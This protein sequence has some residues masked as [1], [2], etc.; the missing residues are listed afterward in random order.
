MMLMQRG[1]CVIPGRAGATTTAASAHLRAG[2]W[3]RKHQSCR[4]TEDKVSLSV[5]FCHTDTARHSFRCLLV[6]EDAGS[7]FTFR[8]SSHNERI[9]GFWRILRLDTSLRRAPRK[10][11]LVQIDSGKG[12]VKM[13]GELFLSPAH[14]YRNLTIDL[15][16]GS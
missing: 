10:H 1:H 5:Q 16:R 2:W 12:H 9:C 8:N 6:V 14:W 3:T 13:N 4:F 15:R 7:R 11:G